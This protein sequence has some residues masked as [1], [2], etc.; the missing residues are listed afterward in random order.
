MIKKLV[1]ENDIM[2]ERNHSLSSTVEYL[3]ENDKNRR[4]KQH[5][6][7]KF[8]IKNIQTMEVLNIIYSVLRGSDQRVS[9]PE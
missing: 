1:N 4:I 2:K 7:D 3:M 8:R 9:R 6:L 5:E